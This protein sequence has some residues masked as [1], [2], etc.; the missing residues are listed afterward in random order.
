ML[1]TA[2]YIDALQP[3]RP[4]ESI[5]SVRQTTGVQDVIKLASNEH[6]TGPSP[7]VLAA[8]QSALHDLHRYPDGGTALQAALAAHYGVKPDEVTVSNGS[9]SLILAIVRA[10]VT[11][12]GEVVTSAGSFAQNVLMPR[13]RGAIMREAPLR[14]YAYDLPALAELIGPKTQLVVLSNPNNPT[15]TYFTRTA[16]EQFYARVPAHIPI[17]LDEAYAE[18]VADCADWPNGL[19]DRRDNVIVLRTFSK[20]YGLAGLRIG[21]AI[22]APDVIATLNKVRLPFEPN[23]IA[24]AAG[25]AAL[26]DQA[27]VART[28]AANAAE[29]A[30]IAA[31]LQ[32]YPC[33]VVPSAANFVMLA[34][35]DTSHA[36]ALAAAL[37]DRG[38]IIRP[39]GAFGLPHAVRISVGTPDENTRLLAALG[40]FFVKIGVTAKEA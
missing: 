15:G 4:G 22:A 24:I 2:P 37:R 3:Y 18:F 12:G 40:E 21:Y 11:E 1:K 14:D 16:W 9:D 7:T 32:H 35:A 19:H 29:R 36:T 13:S 5:E 31:A 38:I 39:L 23:S 25:V 27:H 30:R 20:A 34:C 28:V 26:A 6:P 10:F 33:T 8:I 17:I